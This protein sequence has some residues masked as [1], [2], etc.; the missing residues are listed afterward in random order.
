MSE[1]YGRKPSILIPILGLGLFSFATAAAKDIQTV[2]ITRF[3]AGVFGGAPLS[4]VGGVLADVFSPVQRGP[5][6]LLWGL[7]ITIGPLLAPIVGGAL[8]TAE[9]TV[10][11]RWAEYVCY[12]VM[13]I[14]GFYD[15]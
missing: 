4:N 8:V 5:A 9:P 7:T 10:G 1:A 11:W 6:L 13:V 15:D 3:F 12:C 2:L 14:C